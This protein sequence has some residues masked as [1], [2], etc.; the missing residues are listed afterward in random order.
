MFDRTETAGL[1]YLAARDSA[2]AQFAAAWDGTGT[3]AEF[4]D[5]AAPWVLRLAEA[6]TSLES[7][8]EPLVNELAALT[9]RTTEVDEIRDLAMNHYFAWRA[10]APALA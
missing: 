4:D 10:Y 2:E 8:I 3:S 7:T 5:A 9:L 6:A 1:A